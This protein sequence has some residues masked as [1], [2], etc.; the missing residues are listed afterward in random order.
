MSHT[1]KAAVLH[2]K[3]DLRID[4]I[5]HPGQPGPGEVLIKMHT[6]GI[7]G[8]DVHYYTHGRIGPYVVEEPM[9]LGHEGSGTVLAVGEGVTHLS[10]GQRVCME[11]GIPNPRSRATLEGRYNIDPDVRFWAT[12]PVDGCLAEEVIHP[13][14]FTFALPDALSYAEGALIEPFAVAVHSAT[15]AQ[16]RPGDVAAVIGCG[17]IGILTA[18]AALAGGASRVIVTDIADEKLALIAEVPG[19][20]TC[21][22]A[23]TSLSEVLDAH[24]GGWGPQVVCECSGASA[25]FSNLWELPAP[26][27]TVVIVGIPT[28]DDVPYNI[29]AAQAR[30][31][32]IENVF[33]YANVYPKAIDMAASPSL[34]LSRL[35]TTT[36]CFDDVVDAFDRGAQARPTDTK[37]QICFE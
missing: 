7:C 26:G 25:P 18:L 9:V 36:F 27:G 34:D 24:T 20:I 4:T 30:E 33:R 17:T 14:A 1:I 32:R 37:L 16:I 6:V 31:L 15:K 13:A 12:P 28:D 5:P 11:P 35:V 29:T 21:N 19:I 23:T 2:S 3:G 22:A 8:S 10:P